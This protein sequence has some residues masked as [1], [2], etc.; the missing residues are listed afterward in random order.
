MAAALLAAPLTRALDQDGGFTLMSYGLEGSKAITGALASSL[1]SFMVFTISIILL[2]I[3][4]ASGQLSPRIIERILESHLVKA[5]LSVFVFSFT[6]TLA[7]LGRIEDRVPQ[8]PVLLAVLLSL[9]SI[10]VFL[11]LIQKTGQTLRPVAI[12]HHVA[13]ATRVA[14]DAVYPDPFS[15]GPLS[16]RNEFTPTPEQWMIKHDGPAGV[17]LAFDADGIVEI[18]RRSDCVVEVVPLIGDFLA[19]G[20]ELFRLHGPGVGIM[21]TNDDRLRRCV[22]IG[23]E[24]VVDN[25]PAFGV[26][27]LVDI[28]SKALSPAINDPTTATLVVDQIELLLR[29]LCQRQHGA[30]VRRDSSD[31]VRLVFRTPGWEEFVALAVTELRI[32][33]AGNPQVTRRLQAMFQALLQVVP[34]ERAGT[35]RE[36]IAL[37]DRTIEAGFTN[38]EDR[39]MARTADSQGFGGARRENAQPA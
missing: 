10:A 29:H 19:T 7:V 18:A 35:L 39:S 25:D 38:H 24:R 22:A 8:L 4:I 1:L 9:L 23:P 28:A 5:A 15:I 16:A 12:L 21:E 31:R 11:Y 34:A 6:Y 26:R 20:A 30:G 36:E 33:G 32:Y 14:I 17:L 3:Q 37:L 13:A 2:V 27:I